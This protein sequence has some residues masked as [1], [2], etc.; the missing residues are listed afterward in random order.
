MK[1]ASP[2]VAAAVDPDDAEKMFPVR[3][4]PVDATTSPL[5]PTSAFPENEAS[6]PAVEAFAARFKNVAAPVVPEE[7]IFTRLPV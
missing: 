1:R 3:P 4:V 2:F 6:V 7:E 5:P